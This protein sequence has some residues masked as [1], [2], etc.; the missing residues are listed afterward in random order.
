MLKLCHAREPAAPVVPLL[1]VVVDDTEDDVSLLRQLPQQG[2]QL[3][4]S[5]VLRSLPTYL[6]HLDDE[7]KAD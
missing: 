6:K 1:S 5:A 4:N 7:E 2:A 3:D